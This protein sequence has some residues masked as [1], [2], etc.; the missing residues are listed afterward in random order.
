MGSGGRDVDVVTT[1]VSAEGPIFTDAFP[2]EVNTFVPRPSFASTDASDKKRDAF[3]CLFARNTIDTT[4]PLCPIKPGFGKPPVKVTVPSPFE[5]TGS[6]G[7]NE[8]I[9]ELLLTDITSSISV[10]KW[11]VAAAVLMDSP[12]L[13]TLMLNETILPTDTFDVPGYTD[14]VAA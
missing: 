1:G 9:E 12:L 8:N 4:C 10:G 2:C 13:F 11:S 6:C 7:H 3:P 14:N 5:N